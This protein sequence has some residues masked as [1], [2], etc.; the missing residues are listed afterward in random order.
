MRINFVDIDGINTRYLYEGDPKNYPLMLI[1]GFGGCA[2]L[3]IRNIDV[4][5]DEFFVVVPDMVAHGFTG[6]ADFGGKPPHP[7][8]VDHL[9]KLADALG[10]DKFCANGSSYG[11]LIA[12]LMYFERPNQVNK[13]VI[14]G[15]GSCFNS[16]EEL[17]S[18]LQGAKNN[19]L[20][21]MRAATYDS[22]R[23]R[24]GNIV[25]DASVVPEAILL[26]QLTSYAFDHMIPKYE[27]AMNGMMDIAASR[28]YRILERLDQL[29]V[30][31]LVAWGREDPRGIYANAVEASKKMPRATLQT[32][33]KCGHL[34]FLEHPDQWNN[35]VRAFLKA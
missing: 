17:A 7:K 34:P 32:F 15:S 35:A 9:L 4:L 28:P 2:D 11:A 29:D 25:F 30:D 8:H 6:P 22:C 21:A 26:P 14:N 13:L 23:A 18:A 19:A 27:E 5:A 1:H 12:A 3:F 24:T 16:E 20:T 33:E 31:T 10:F